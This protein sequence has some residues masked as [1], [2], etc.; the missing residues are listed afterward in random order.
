MEALNDGSARM[1]STL[2]DN[3]S[4][5]DSDYFDR[6]TDATMKLAV[7]FSSSTGSIHIQIL[8][9]ST[10]FSSSIT[11]SEIDGLCASSSSNLVSLFTIS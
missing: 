3:A 4:G 2:H 8:P 9:G 5:G 10:D 1:K 6:P 7:V 11:A